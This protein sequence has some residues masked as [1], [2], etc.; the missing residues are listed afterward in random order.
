MGVEGDVRGDAVRAQGRKSHYLRLLPTPP[1]PTPS[2]PP[3]PVLNLSHYQ[4]T[5]TANRDTYTQSALQRVCVCVRVFTCQ[6]CVEDIWSPFFLLPI[7]NEAPGFFFFFFVFR[8]NTSVFM[9]ASTCHWLVSFKLVFHSW[10]VNGHFTFKCLS[11]VFSS[12][13]TVWLLLNWKTRSLS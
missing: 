8:G 6:I 11:D 9:P 5:L 2:P 1:T 3:H 4:L 13:T 7:I 12:S 10:H